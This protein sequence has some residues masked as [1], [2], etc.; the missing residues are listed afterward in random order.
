MY[1]AILHFR[2]Y[3]IIVENYI[4]KLQVNPSRKFL[5]MKDIMN[6]IDNIEKGFNSVM[7][8]LKTEPNDPK[9]TD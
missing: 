6:E 3:T 8:K 7:D 4:Y 1:F 5:T 2:G 9:K